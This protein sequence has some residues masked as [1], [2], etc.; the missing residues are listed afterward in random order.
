MP[1]TVALTG[2]QQ[3]AQSAVWAGALLAAVVVVC[4]TVLLYCRWDR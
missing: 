1:L 3:V 2:A 4:V